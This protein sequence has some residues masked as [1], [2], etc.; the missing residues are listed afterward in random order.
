MIET[1]PI[2][3]GQLRAISEQFGKPAS[4]LLDFSA[5]INPEGPPISV[6]DALRA[7]VDSPVTLTQY[8]DFSQGELKKSIAQHLGSKRENI[9]VANG[10]VPLLDAAL[11]TLSIRHCLL[12]VP[13]F[14]EY[15]TTLA[16]N[17]IEI[18]HH[19]LRPEM[20]F[21]YDAPRML[22]DTR[23]AILLANPQNP[24]GVLLYREAMIDVVERAASQNIYVL[25]DEA[26]IDYAPHESLVPHIDRFSNLIVFRSVTKFYGMPGLRVAYAVA[27]PRLI[28]QLEAGIAPWPI[29]TLAS[30]AAIAALQDEEYEHKTLCLNQVR[31][32]N[33]R[34]SLEASGFTV[35]LSA[36][37]FLLLRLPPHVDAVKVWGMLISSDGIV[38]R[39]CA[40]YHG[41][42]KGHLRV[43]VRDEQDN[44]RLIDALRRI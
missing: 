2:H 33:L 39:S 3:G 32:K 31:R 36:A 28:A 24:S 11:R 12:P 9:V 20:N 38:A 44:A 25:L 19:V 26:F 35:Y 14:S 8:P 18:K 41:L 29:S 43:A 42:P 7:C 22:A 16:R 10:F 27:S 6:I 34:A 15:Q 30:R 37:N 17:G 13:A 5:N 4:E 23:E 40:N 1:L 21:H